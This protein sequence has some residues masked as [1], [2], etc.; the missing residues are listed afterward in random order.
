[1]TPGKERGGE[2]FYWLARKVWQQRDPSVM[3]TEARL[4]AAAMRGAEQYVAA[5]AARAQAKGGQP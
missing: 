5:M 1:M 3:P 4:L 2:V